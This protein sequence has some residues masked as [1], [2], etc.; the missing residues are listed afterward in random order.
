MGLNEFILK[1]IIK[2]DYIKEKK[3]SCEPFRICLLNSSA[4]S[5]QIFGEMGWIG[6]AI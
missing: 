3:K 1:K 5:A 2:N 6:C 4:N